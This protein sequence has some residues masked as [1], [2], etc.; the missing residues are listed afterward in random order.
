MKVV[1][2]DADGVLVDSYATYRRIW[3][4]W[5]TVHLLDPDQVWAATHARRA[6]DTVREIA[7]HLDAEDEYRRLRKYMTEENDGFPLFEGV[8]D[9]LNRLPS[10][11]WAIVTSGRDT[12]VRHR[13]AAGGAAGPSVLVDGAMVT[14]GK[15]AP[16]GYLLAAEL[17]SADPRDCLVVE[18]AP[19]GIEAAKHAG[20]HVIAVATTHNR[21]DLHRADQVVDSFPTAAEHVTTWMNL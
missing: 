8:R 21:E 1:L 2:F 9:L 20:M 4:R 16:D 15:P 5:S 19:A 3:N 12:H 11:R 10:D 13:L 6:T 14:V 7:P 18:D 17:L